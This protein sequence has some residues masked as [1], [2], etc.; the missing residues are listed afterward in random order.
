MVCAVNQAVNASGSS[1]AAVP[2]CELSAIRNQL[3]Q[4][5]KSVSQQLQHLKDLKNGLLT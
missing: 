4:Y 1:H 3:S 5:H 2:M